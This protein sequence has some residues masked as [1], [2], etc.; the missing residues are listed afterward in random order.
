MSDG[1]VKQEL[2]RFSRWLLIVYFT[3]IGGF[4]GWCGRELMTWRNVIVV[5]LPPVA[6]TLVSLI[7]RW[8][9]NRKLFL[10]LVLAPPHLFLGTIWAGFSLLIAWGIAEAVGGW[11]ALLARVVTCAVMSLVLSALALYAYKP[12]NP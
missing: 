5:V 8:L 3:F 1:S 6:I 10:L 4:A 9:P 7:H 2:N 11:K 12:R